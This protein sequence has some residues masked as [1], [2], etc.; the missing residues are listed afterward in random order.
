MTKTTKRRAHSPRRFSKQNLLAVHHG[1]ARLL[2]KRL[3]DKSIDVTITSPPYFDMKDYGATNQIGFGQDYDTYLADLR[4]VF[5]E[6]FRATKSRGSLWVVVDSFRRNQEVVPLPFDLAAQL[7]P[8]GWVLR[9]VIIWKKERTLPWTHAGTTR[10]IFE[11]IMVFSK[12][13]DAFNYYPDAHRETSDLKRWWVRYPERY[14]PKGKSLEEIWSYDIP[15]QGSWGDSYRQHFCPLPAALVSRIISLTTKPGDVVLDPFSGSGT[16]PTTAALMDRLFV[17]FELNNT[18]IQMFHEYLKAQVEA[19]T[20]SSL[21]SQTKG[22]EDFEKTILD[23][24]TLKFARMLY[25]TLTKHAKHNGLRVFTRRL[26]EKPKTS[27]KLV[28][29]EFNIFGLPKRNVKAATA[30]L[31]EL[32][33]K[34]PLSKYGID[35]RIVFADTI[36]E[37]PECYTRKKVFLYTSTNSHSYKAALKLKDISDLRHPVVSTIQ[38]NVGEPDE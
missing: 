34:P 26:N 3:P 35:H 37:L 6:I 5:G 11:Y 36:D 21:T 27:H 22:I 4:L 19:R 25:R 20:D 7:K 12:G 2:S 9:D 8:T 33:T 13:T 29:A 18:Y 14:N 23:L 16:V 15:T 38:V 31:N 1:D 17:G 28:V 10:R 32:C 24:R 30:T